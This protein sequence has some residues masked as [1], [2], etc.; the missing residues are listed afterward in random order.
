MLRDEWEFEYTASVLAEA[1]DEQRAFRSGRVDWWTVKQA[2]IMAKIRESGISVHES[3]GAA[4]SNT[5]HGYGPQVMIDTTLQRDLTEC[6]SKIKEHTAA[7]KAYGAWVQVLKANAQS[8]IK[9][10]HDDWFY[11]FGK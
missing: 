7:M 1:A 5:T 4:Y 3:P 9:L 6:A 10:H 8:R 11:F 2:E